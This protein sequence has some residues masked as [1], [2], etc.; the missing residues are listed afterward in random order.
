VLRGVEGVE[1][2]QGATMRNE[3]PPTSDVARERTTSETAARGLRI[4]AAAAACGVSP[5]ALRYYERL[6]LLPKA[7]RTSGGFRVY[8]P[9]VTTRVAFI[10]QARALGLTLAEI[11]D[12]VGAERGGG[13]ARCRRVRDLL[14]RHLQELDARV[15]ALKALRRTLAASLERCEQVLGAD[16]AGECPVVDTL[17][18]Q[19][20]AGM[21]RAGRRP[22]RTRVERRATGGRAA[23]PRTSRADATG[24]RLP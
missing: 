23:P 17:R 2:V 15:A 8:G 11:R 12:I 20:V 6:G 4:G 9:E 24:G 7:S 18:G 3:A 13:A 14:A 1:D 22:T 21:V 19:A 16:T 5:D 10:R